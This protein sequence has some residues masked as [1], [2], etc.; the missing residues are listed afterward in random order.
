MVVVAEAYKSLPCEVIKRICTRVVEEHGVSIA[1]IM[2]IK[3]RSISKTTSGK[4]R[5]FEVA[6]RFIDGTLSVVEDATDGEKS[7]R[8]SKDGSVP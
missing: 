7:S 3:P 5:R 4:I 2:T 8:E 1:S 6:K